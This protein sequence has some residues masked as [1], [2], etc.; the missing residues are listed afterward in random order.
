MKLTSKN[1]PVLIRLTVLFMIVLTLA[2]ALLERLLGLAGIS[3]EI[4][5]GPIGF[6]LTV[7]AVWMQ[8]NPGTLLGV[9]PA[10]LVFRKL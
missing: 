10:M 9:L 2:W 7:L 4:S 1:L 5:T 8:F 3:M 6:D